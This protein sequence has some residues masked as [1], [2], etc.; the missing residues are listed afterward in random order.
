MDWLNQQMHAGAHNSEELSYATIFLR[1][2]A[3]MVL[4]CVVA[5][6]HYY[7][8]QKDAPSTNGFQP[9]IVLLTILL[10]M[11]VLAVGDNIA[12]SFTLA[13]VL[14]IVRFRT[15]V[16]DTR[17]SAFVIC[18]VIVGMAAGIG[19]LKVALIGL[20]VVAV[21]AYFTQFAQAP[22]PVRT[23]NL[24]LRFVNTNNP[25]T[26]VETILK[27]YVDAFSIKETSTCKKGTSLD[28][29]YRIRLKKGMQTPDLV[30]ELNAI[31][32]MQAVEWKS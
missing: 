21:A 24:H 3:A 10:A 17:D 19:Y 28:V 7:T 29:S 26:L 1:I 6:I 22:K 15:V 9:T 25:Q 30:R 13:G 12:R 2:I 4:G 20:P 31:E 16:K 18:A 32:G 14:A 5:C 11:V 23:S 27:R 8:R